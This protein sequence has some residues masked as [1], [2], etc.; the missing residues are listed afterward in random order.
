MIRKRD[1]AIIFLMAFAFSLGLWPAGLRYHVSAAQVQSAALED[2]TWEETQQESVQTETEQPESKETLPSGLVKEKNGKLYFYENGKAVKRKLVTVSGKVYYFGSDGSAMMNRWK[3]VQGKTYYFGS[4]GKAFQGCRKV[5]GSY[6]VFLEDCSLSTDKSS[7]IVK[8]NGEKYYVSKKGKAKS[9]WNI[10][11]NKALYAEKTGRMVT[12]KK[13]SYIRLNEKG[14]A[15][16]K[17][18]G[19]AKIYAAN[20]IKAHTKK[21]MS[22][23]E[24]LRTCFYYMLRHRRYIAHY[25]RDTRAYRTN[26]WQ[27][28]A[29][30]DMLCDRRLEGNCRNFAASLAAIAKELGYKPYVWSMKAHSVVKINGK[31]YDSLRGVGMFGGDRLNKYKKPNIFKF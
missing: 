25:V 8:L 24:K 9:G 16:N 22:R 19:L 5:D 18:Q 28:K 20:F 11:K 15:K 6:Y 12:N 14:F 10:Y 2:E 4:K 30:V 29:A 23:K 31:Y 7:H 3:K 17:Y 27:Y 1:A 13:V 21:S 26:T